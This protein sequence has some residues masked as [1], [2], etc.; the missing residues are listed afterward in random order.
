MVNVSGSAPVKPLFGVKTSPFSAAFISVAVPRNWTV[1]RPLAVPFRNVNP[2][3]V[4]S[5]SVP[6]ATLSDTSFEPLLASISLLFCEENVSG[7][8]SVVDCAAGYTSEAGAV[9][10][11]SLGSKGSSQ[12][13][14]FGLFREAISL[15]D[16]A[17]ARIRFNKTRHRRLKLAHLW[18]IKSTRHSRLFQS[19]DPFGSQSTKQG[20]IWSNKSR[21]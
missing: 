17:P 14:D 1:A 15:S 20:V 11:R 6:L 3:V 12:P 4:E 2:L 16:V 18:K 21:I 13:G 19:I 9:L 5:V 10:I 8:F 7:T